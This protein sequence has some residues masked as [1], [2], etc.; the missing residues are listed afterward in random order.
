MRPRPI[1]RLSSQDHAAVAQ[2]SRR[3]T[4]VIATA[5]AVLL[6]A[7]WLYQGNDEVNSSARAGATGVAQ[8]QPAQSSS[9]LRFDAVP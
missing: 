2:W 6:A 7:V 5:A 1:V 3:T 8:N 9:E 4:L